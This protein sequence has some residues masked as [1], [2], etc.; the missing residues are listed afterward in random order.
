MEFRITR[1]AETTTADAVVELGS[2]TRDTTGAL[3]Q[4]MRPEAKLLAIEIA[5]DFCALPRS[6][7]QSLAPGAPLRRL[8]VP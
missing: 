7:E 8:P 2:G 5:P 6:V 1:T 4:A 3:I